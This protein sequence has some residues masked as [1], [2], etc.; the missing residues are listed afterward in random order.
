MEEL[1]T[2]LEA[3]QLLLETRLQAAL[4]HGAN[5]GVGFHGELVE[6]E[7]VAAGEEG[8]GG[9]LRVACAGLRQQVGGPRDEGGPLR[10]QGDEEVGVV[11]GFEG[12]REAYSGAGCVGTGGGLDHG[13]DHVDEIVGRADIPGG[14]D[15]SLLISEVLHDAGEQRRPG[16]EPVGGGPFG[17]AGAGVDA[18]V[19]QGADPVLAYLFDGRVEGALPGDR[20]HV[21]V[22][23]LL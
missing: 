17:Q 18:G 11:G 19:G 4:D 5:L 6:Q 21:T 16:A 12:E 22:A 1:A 20:H 13:A 7:P 23:L 10:L 3:E 8:S 2:A 15:G 9:L 14:R